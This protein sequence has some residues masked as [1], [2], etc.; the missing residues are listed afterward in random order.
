MRLSILA[1]WLT[2]GCQQASTNSGAGGTPGAGTDTGD[3]S[4]AADG[5]SSQDAT[6]S[7]GDASGT[8]DTPVAAQDTASGQDA[9]ETG[10]DTAGGED[11][12]DGA[13]ADGPSADDTSGDTGTSSCG[14][15][16]CDAGETNA[17]CPADCPK[18]TGHYCDGNCGKQA[19]SGCYCDDQCP[20]YGDCCLADGTKPANPNKSCAGSTCN[21][22]GG[23][24]S[25]CGNGKCDAGETNASCPAD[26]PKV[27]GHYC[28]SNCGKK[29]PSGCHCDDQCTKFGDCCLEDGT[30]PATPNKSCSGSTCNLCGSSTTTCKPASCDDSNPCTVDVCDTAKGVCGNKPAP[31][32]TACGTNKLC[33]AGVCVD[34]SKCSK[35]ADCDDKDPCTTD[36]C[37]SSGQ[38]LNKDVADGTPCQGGTCQFG[39]CTNASACTGASDCNDGN[40]CTTDTCDKAKGA[41]SFTPNADP[42][43]LDGSSC[44]G[45]KCSF[46]KCVAGPVIKVCNDNDPC[47]SNNCDKSGNCVYPPAPDGEYCGIGMACKAGVCAKSTS[48]AQNSNCNDNNPC[49]SDTCAKGQCVFAPVPDGEQGGCA[50]G[51]MCVAGKCSFGCS[52][53]AEC[54]DNDSCTVDECKNG[55]CSNVANSA[56]DDKNPCTKDTCDKSTGCSSAPM[57]ILS[58]CDDSN[59]CTVNDRCWGSGCYGTFK[60]CTDD[61]FCTEETCDSKTGKCS[62]PKLISGMMCSIGKWCTSDTDPCQPVQ[63]TATNPCVATVEC[64]QSGCCSVADAVTKK[65]GVMF[66]WNCKM[67]CKLDGLCAPLFNTSSGCS[68][69]KGKCEANT[70]ENCLKSKQCLELGKCTMVGKVC[71]QANDADCAHSLAC[72][73]YGDCNLAAGSCQPTTDAACKQSDEC[74]KTGKCKSSQLL[75][76]KWAC[77]K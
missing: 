74:A 65:C 51:Q 43:D 75:V 53:N 22:C 52:A 10:Q 24:A 28:D 34:A 72:K 37:E 59:P 9:P 66:D 19:P 12:A 21:L 3:T 46:G 7:G 35:N 2:I 27:A 29:A 70:N 44:T 62:E 50:V 39:Q 1:A 69:G 77:V 17:N 63:G 31:D 6:A 60:D 56:C 38:C 5:A 8:P 73:W 16:K 76:D 26:C 48:C 11:A 41:C 15:G 58:V 64:Y 33:A 32:G 54:N 67:Q 61:S 23:G 40:A 14:N 57:P 18:P 30:K 13:V 36:V 25:S 42:C 49:T 4:P 47:T 71:A 20:Q 55:L 45:D 68:G